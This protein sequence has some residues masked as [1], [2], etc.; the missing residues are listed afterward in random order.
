MRVAMSPPMPMIRLL[1]LLLW[2]SLLLATT[3]VLA[4][5]A[6]PSNDGAAPLPLTR[7]KLQV[8]VDSG[9][10]VDTLR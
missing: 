10:V 3:S 9:I 5:T 1:P 6:Q 8:L 7:D 2:M 4:L